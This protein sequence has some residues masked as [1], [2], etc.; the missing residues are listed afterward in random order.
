MTN[1]KDLFWNTW[2][3]Y[4]F[5]IALLTGG[6]VFGV[7]LVQHGIPDYARNVVGMTENE[8]ST[9][10]V[11]LGIISCI[12]A[13][14]T[15]ILIDKYHLS[16]KTRFRINGLIMIVQMVATNTI[17]LAITTP[18]FIIWISIFSVLVGMMFPLSFSYM[19][20]MIPVKHRGYVAGIITSGTYIISNVSPVAWDFGGMMNATAITAA[21]AIILMI[22]LFLKKGLIESYEIT[23]ER[24]IDYEKESNNNIFAVLVV[25]MFAIYFIDSF[26]F[27]RIINDTAIYNAT[28]NGSFDIRL[29]IA[30]AHV[31]PA[32]LMGY[33]YQKHGEKIVLICTFA[34]FFV[35][36]L[37]FMFYPSGLFLLF[38]ASIYCA[39]V[40]FYTINTFAIWADNSN[41]ENVATYSGIGVGVGGW[42]SSFLSTA[43]TTQLFVVLPN[44]QGFQVHLGIT[45]L[46]ALFFLLITMLYINRIKINNKAE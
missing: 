20:F 38:C 16:L 25:L 11:L 46:M 3:P 9:C 19:F 2:F 17:Y 21:P 41:K 8:I 23:P 42:L 29:L 7:M 1:K 37:L 33:L 40:S 44:V 28:W 13:V 22:V 10:M 24:S 26:G 43:I 39:V 5:V 15:G 35:V 36:D 12:S 31:I 6:Y 30:T 27:L 34:I 4:L 32:L 14:I 45:S 18:L